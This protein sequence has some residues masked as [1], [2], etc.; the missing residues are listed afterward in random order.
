MYNLRNLSLLFLLF[1]PILGYS[2]D[3]D[4]SL[5]SP[6]QDWGK[7]CFQSGEDENCNVRYT[8]YTKQGQLVV[9]VNLAI[10]TGSVSRR[11]FQVVVP[12]WRSIPSG[13]EM[14]IDDRTQN[15][16]AYS[17]CLPNR[18]VAEV[19]LSDE[20]LSALKGGS[21]INFVSTN[22]RNKRNPVSV[23]LDG[24]TVAYDGPALEQEEV[25]AQQRQLEDELQKKAD[26][27]RRKL[28]EAQEK[29]KSGG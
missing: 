21:E 1:C 19:P 14:Q 29:A 5:S 22:F 12:S 2:Q 13:I 4:N 28:K 27:T 25:E 3:L 17:V 11:I 6:E 18:C 26:E 24:F 23:T 15:V 8:L 20:L 7:I 9:G 10:R 16:L